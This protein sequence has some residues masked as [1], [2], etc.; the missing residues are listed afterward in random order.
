[1]RTLLAQAFR[2]DQTQVSTRKVC[3]LR[4]PRFKTPREASPSTQ[5]RERTDHHRW[6][7]WA[8]CHTDHCYY[9]SGS[10]ITTAPQKLL[11]GVQRRTRSLDTH[12]AVTPGVEQDDGHSQSPPDD[13]EH[14]LA[15]TT[16]HLHKGEPGSSTSALKTVLSL[17]PIPRDVT[18]VEQ[19]TL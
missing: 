17:L 18:G 9:H 15:H 11:L 12:L 3:I 8:T 14:P 10:Q 7:Q 16:D 2:A 19:N 6:E 1:M 13:H 4:P 5:V